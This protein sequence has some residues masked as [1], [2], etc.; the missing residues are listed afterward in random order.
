[1]RLKISA[2]SSSAFSLIE[3]VLAI[4]IVSFALV[5]LMGLF[6]TAINLAQDSQRETQAALIAKRIFSN[7]SA[8]EPFIQQKGMSPTEG[9]IEK[10]NLATIGAT[11]TAVDY[12]ESGLLP[13]AVG[14]DSKIISSN[15][16]VYRASLT[17]SA[18]T[19]MKDIAKADLVITTPI[20]APKDHQR[21]FYFT[22]LIAV[23]YRP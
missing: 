7:L 12:D 13:G 20:N 18:N 21:T 9:N 17:I 8:E 6:P 19:P 22:T 5:G 10:I 14:E 1:M 3:L 11:P 23:P 16:P 15:T 2:C 4:G